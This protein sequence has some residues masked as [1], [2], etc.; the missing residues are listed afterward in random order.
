MLLLA[1]H[2]IVLLFISLYDIL[3]SYR[4]FSRQ[5]GQHTMQIAPVHT[6]VTHRQL[7]KTIFYIT[8]GGE[9]IAVLGN[10][11]MM[12]SPEEATACFFS[13]FWTARLRIVN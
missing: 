8:P 11:H 3:I 10:I 2:I 7:Y 6:T 13:A 5:K 12:I 1:L 4:Y 9:L